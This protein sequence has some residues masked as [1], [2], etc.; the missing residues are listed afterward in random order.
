MHLG[1][2]IYTRSNS[3]YNAYESSV[4]YG[5]KYYPPK[6]FHISNNIL[7]ILLSYA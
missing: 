4:V 2:C 3:G 7:R 6:W 1:A 5:C